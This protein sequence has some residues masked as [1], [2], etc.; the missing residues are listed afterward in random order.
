VFLRDRLVS[1]RGRGVFTRGRVRIAAAAVAAG[2]VL[3][4][5]AL[6]LTS[7]SASPAR[8]VTSV[9]LVPPP[10]HQVTPP[11]LNCARDLGH[12]SAN[13]LLVVL[14][15]SVTAGVGPGSPD[16]SWAVLLA[17]ALHW[18]AVVYGVPGAGYVR[19]GSGKRGPVTAEVARIDL[20]ALDP[21][22]IIIQA[23]H[24]DIGVPPA[25]EQQQVAQTIS[26]VR[27]EA[28]RARI[29]LVT[30]FQGRAKLARA[31][32]TDQAIVA[33]AT[34]AD[35]DVIIMD[36]LTGRWPYQRAADGLHPT[37][38]GSDWLAR[39]IGGVLRDHGVQAV[40]S[41]TVPQLCDYSILGGHQA[42]GHGTT[43]HGTAGRGGAGHRRGP[44]Y[45]PAVHYGP[46]D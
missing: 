42:A 15:A 14:G 9:A 3:T 44:G 4:G 10:V 16:R 5:L 38:A 45:R 27:A 39:E 32:L 21:A 19:R 30:V 33:G 46:P 6:V 36:P 26:L 34:E 2:A 37:V 12:T 11:S 1:T 20:S 17:R 7:S 24:D 25:I 40:A 13:H 28:P 31:L 29:A 23:G 22:L 35:P 43:G 41:G 18:N 8:A